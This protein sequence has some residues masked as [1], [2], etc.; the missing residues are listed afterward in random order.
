MLRLIKPLLYMRTTGLFIGLMLFMTPLFAQN[1]VK[2]TVFLDANSNNKFDKKESVIEG[3]AVS[4]GREVVLTGKD[5]KYALP[6]GT[7]DVI[8]VIKPSGYE[9]PLNDKNLPQFYYIHKPNGSP[10]LKYPGVK[11]TGKLPK[12]V[13]FGLIK[14]D[15][16]EQYDI[17][18]F[19]DPQPYSQ[20]EVEYFDKDIVNELAGAKGYR[21]GM[22]L[23]DIVG[24]DLSLYPYYN[25]SIARIGIPWFNVPGNHD[26][27]Y[28]VKDIEL[29][30]ETWE[31]VFGPAT[32]SFNEGKVHYIVIDDILYPRPDGKGGYIGGFTE[33]QLVF[34]KNDLSFVPKDHLVIVSFHIPT[35][36]GLTK[37][38]A[39]RFD[40]QKALFDLLKPFDNTLTLSAHTHFQKIGFLDEDEGWSGENL[41]LHF[42]VG[43][44]CGDWWSGVPDEDGIP[45]T[46]MRDGTPN[47][48][49]ILHLDGNQY[50][51]DYKI[52]RG[53]ESDKM[54]FWGP[55]AVPQNSWHGAELFVNYYLG[56]EKTKVEYKVD[57]QEWKEMGKSDLDDPGYAVYAYEWD[58]AEKV[59]DGRRPSNPVKS[60]HLWKTGVPNNLSVGGHAIEVKVTD[61]FG[62]VFSETFTYEVVEKE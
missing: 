10:K 49:V 29:A 37:G 25:Q 22:S 42:N 59:L 60:T 45:P 34:L 19:G 36:A 52:A 31:A 4:N 44:S 32:Y 38:S 24:D 54:S 6:V 5:G 53:D 18:V 23:G 2:G 61:M 12:S 41:H 28:D 62:R 46:T 35:F 39:F 7:D 51:Y 48:Y 15:N 16:P 9:L 14:G 11:P 55:K 20:K 33:K 13:N 8:F 21:F 26:M 43:A 17:L 50:T 58:E 1:I 57:D 40:D 56:S 30:D 3:V 47:G 27:N